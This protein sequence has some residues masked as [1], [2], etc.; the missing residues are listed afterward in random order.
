MRPK[1][2]KIASLAQKICTLWFQSF[3]AFLASKGYPFKNTFY[4]SSVDILHNLVDENE[5]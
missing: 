2:P 5:G 3:D 1:W 4:I